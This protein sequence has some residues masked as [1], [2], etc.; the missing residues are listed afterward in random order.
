V[1]VRVPDG[2]KGFG[3]TVATVAE[4]PANTSTWVVPWRMPPVTKLASTVTST[5]LWPLGS[6]E[7][8]VLR[9]AFEKLTRISSIPSPLL[10]PTTKVFV[11]GVWICLP[12]YFRTKL[13]STTSVL[14]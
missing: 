3:A 1:S 2:L 14:A 6:P 5:R 8:R 4:P 7:N 9:S 11:P 13:E 10:S 12:A